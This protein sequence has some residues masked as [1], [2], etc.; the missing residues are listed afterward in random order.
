M[1]RTALHAVKSTKAPI[2]ATE[3][4]VLLGAETGERITVVHIASG[5]LWAGA[6]VQL[7]NLACALDA[8]P[9]I[10]LFV[11]LLN[12]GLLAKRLQERGLSVQVFDEG[13][14]NSAQVFIQVYRFLKQIRPDIVHTHREKE[15]VIGAIAARLTGA[16]SVRTVHGIGEHLPRPWQLHRR[17]HKYVDRLCAL[18]L[19]DGVVA[20]SCD[21]GD[22][23]RAR[24]PQM[25]IHVVENG[26][27]IDRVRD[28]AALSIELPGAASAVKIAFVARMVL[29]K[30]VD[31]FLAAAE[32][33][34][35][36]HPGVFQFYIFGDGP[37]LAETRREIARR[38]LQGQVLLM[39]FTDPVAPYLAHMDLLFITS[40][41][42]GLPM[43][44]LEALSL[45]VPIVAHA[46]GGIPQA[47]D[48]GRCGTLVHHLHAGAYAEAALAYRDH[49]AVFIQKAKEGYALARARYS[50]LANARA[51]KSIYAALRDRMLPDSVEAARENDRD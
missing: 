50:A 25:K 7:F 42:E 26:L 32:V 33:L 49:R 41:H 10:R 46:V 4:S 14:L 19:Q 40:D 9:Q 20:V 15:N 6:E 1:E 2:S 17:L 29:V 47:L 45:Q 38:G 18:H 16:K 11:I 27:D 30:R 35:S 44:L 21:L 12:S 23:L 37:L 51:F 39:G 34:N 13:R 28:S 31:V 8:D 22:K 43:N 36:Q 5:D 3:P 48:G 24:E